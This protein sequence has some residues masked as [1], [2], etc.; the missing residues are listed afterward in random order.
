M[1]VKPVLALL[2][3]VVS[4]VSAG[5]RGPL[6]SCAPKISSQVCTAPVQKRANPCFV[7]GSVA[8]PAEVADGLPALSA[9]TCNT[10]VRS[11]I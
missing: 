4:L 6:P 11:P 1:F 8:L 3:G 9:V 2:F 7:T 5:E 10:K